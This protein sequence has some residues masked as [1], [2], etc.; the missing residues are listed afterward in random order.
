M[1]NAKPSANASNPSSQASGSS[2][3]ANAAGRVPAPA[4]SPSWQ[5][6]GGTEADTASSS[7]ADDQTHGVWQQEL[8]LGFA[9]EGITKLITNS[10]PGYADSTNSIGNQLRH[11]R[12]RVDVAM[13][14]FPPQCA[15][16]CGTTPGITPPTP[17]R[18]STRGGRRCAQLGWT[19]HFTA[20]L[21]TP[22]RL[23]RFVL[24]K[25]KCYA[26]FTLLSHATM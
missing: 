5:N 3:K 22:S 26:I 25:F 24:I 23:P 7:S 2:F 13:S 21:C 9:A 20:T 16:L 10:D 11:H 1:A 4:T 19:H 12:A 6:E 18:L 17:L 14:I 8:Q 15:S